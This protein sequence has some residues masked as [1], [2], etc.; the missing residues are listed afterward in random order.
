MRARGTGRSHLGRISAWK[1][2]VK[3]LSDS[4][5]WCALQLLL[6]ILSYELYQMMDSSLVSQAGLLV[7]Q[8]SGLSKLFWERSW[9]MLGVSLAC[10]VFPLTWEHSWVQILL[11]SH[12]M[13]SQALPK[14]LWEWDIGRQQ[15]W[16]TA[17]YVT[18]ERGLTE[19]DWEAD[20]RTLSQC[21]VYWNPQRHLGAVWSFWN[22]RER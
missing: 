17:L 5:Q 1:I 14:F 6:R 2:G 15:D 3:L 9:Y 20:L 10:T 16:W 13:V 12:G 11:A 8:M 19:T 4:V 22:F 18:S 7:A 21:E